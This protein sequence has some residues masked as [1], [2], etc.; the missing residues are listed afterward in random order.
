MKRI[1]T[2]LILFFAAGLAIA[3]NVTPEKARELAS[4]FF[5]TT[6][7]A[8]EVELVWDGTD[9][10]TRAAASPAF[11]VFNNRGGGF[12]VLSGEDAAV[13]VLGFSETGSFTADNLPS[14][15]RYWFDEYTRQINYLRNTGSKQ[16]AECAALWEQ[17][18]R[19]GSATPTLIQRVETPNWG[20]ESPYNKYCPVVDGGKSLTGCVSTAI[21]E[22]MFVHKWPLTT[23]GEIL[24]DYEYETDKNK[25]QKITGHNLSASYDWN[26][27]KSSY[28]GSYT[29]EQADAV[30]TLMHDVGVMI[31]SSYNPTGTGA[32]SEII[33]EMLIRYMDYDSSAYLAYYE[34]FPTSEWCSMLRA[35]I[36]AGRP[37]LYGGDGD[38]GGHQFVVDGYATD[39][40]FY[41]NWGWTGSDN[42][43]FKISSLMPDGYDFRFNAS[44]V[45]G[46]KKNEG[47]APVDRMLYYLD[48]SYKGGL[49]ITGGS[50]AKGK[51]LKVSVKN[52]CNF[53]VGTFV[54]QIA[55]GITDWKG[56]IK[57]LF[58]PESLELEPE[59]GVSGD[60]SVTIAE[61]PAMG[62][63]LMIFYKGRE[64]EWRP[65]R[66]DPYYSTYMVD[67]LPAYDYPAIQFDNTVVYKAGDT[68][69]LRLVNNASAPSS[70]TWYIDNQK[71]QEGLPSI[72]LTAGKHTIKAVARIGS[73]SQTI[74]Q[75]IKVQ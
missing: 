43:F 53:G 8:A 72:V 63:R 4:A 45:F 31:Q 66:I 16:T 56:N 42:G 3:G 68:F 67:A 54:G 71:Q 20:Q 9:G 17:V 24:D 64:A 58:T 74:Y 25:T 70:L 48:N 51:T 30:A 60:L 55:L 32:Y 37:V 50:Y 34:E 49:S 6:R 46:V 23:G 75:V 12:V 59:Y 13:P 57:T 38:E 14:N 61:E 33:P 62:D 28:R 52:L 10:Q 18:A 36:D 47:G 39:D 69:D 65:V 1:A 35:E 40:Y 15:I 29:T 2:T 21:C 27:M 7:S 19:R 26:N 44:A 5:T 22:V 41:I 11:Y 73:V